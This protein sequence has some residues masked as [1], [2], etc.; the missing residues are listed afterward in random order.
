MEQN[1]H[2]DLKYLVLG[3]RKHTGNTQRT[4]AERL[5]VPLHIETSLEMG[6]YKYP[7]EILM[8]KILEITSE[9][10]QNELIQI[11][12]GYWIKDKLGPNFKYFIRG[13]KPEKGIEQNELNELSDEECYKII[14]RENMDEY[15]VVEAGRNL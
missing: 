4:L 11:G 2:E 13:L 7:T 8:T 15:K 5:D 9:H 1:I 3:Y 12:R 6:T 14:G 10:D